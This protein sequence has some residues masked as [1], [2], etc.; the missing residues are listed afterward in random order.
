MTSYRCDLLIKYLVSAQNVNAP[1]L[2]KEVETA[3][4]VLT[5]IGSVLSMV[6]LILT[7]LTMLIFKYGYGIMLLL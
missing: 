4:K 5:I 1:E 6:G 7:I 2:S 3:L